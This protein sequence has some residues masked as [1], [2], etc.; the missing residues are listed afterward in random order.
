[1]E[2]IGVDLDKTLAE[3]HDFQGMLH[4]GKPI[5]KMVARVVDWLAEGRTVKILT[6]RAYPNGMINRDTPTVGGTPLHLIIKAIQD[7]CT[8]HIGQALEVTCVKTIHMTELWDDRAVQV[9]PNTGERVGEGSSKTA[10]FNPDAFA[11]GYADLLHEVEQLRKHRATLVVKYE[12][13]R[14]KYEGQV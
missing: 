6:A 2:W 11:Q 3:Y 8:E 14:A 7:W 1:M 9:V 4:I 5:P 13:L 10:D 12:K